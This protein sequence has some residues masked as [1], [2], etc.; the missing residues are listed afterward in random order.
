MN[1]FPPQQ[2]TLAGILAKAMAASRTRSSWNDRLAHWERPASNTEEAQIERAAGMVRRV[3]A[4]NQ[5]LTSEGVAIQAQ[6]SYFNNTNVR[7]EA[8]MDLRA[9]HPLIYTEYGDGVV[10]A[11]AQQASGRS[12]VDRFGDEV[13]REMRR[14]MA[15]EFERAFGRGVVTVGTKAIR[16]DKK[17][18]SRADVDVVPTVG[19]RWVTWCA[20]TG[21]YHEE[22]GIAIFSENGD[23][24]RNYPD[25]HNRNGIDKRSRTRLRF[26]RIVRSLKWLRDELVE[27]GMLKLKQVP[28]FLIECLVYLV[29]DSAFLVEEDDRFDRI[30]RVLDELENMVSDAAMVQNATELNGI[31][32]LFHPSQPWT[33]ADAKA[34]VA[35]AK[36]RLKY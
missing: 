10:P 12:L 29:P 21:S 20:L 32:Y 7:Q 16:I 34:F 19:Y 25:Q 28:S 35:A 27:I 2:N 33:V 30:L 1:A 17:I 14:E 26:K 31:K 24:T 18:G 4:G 36:A 23:I 3:F 5:F 13:C 22:S 15:R 9:T 6:G 11:Y 8:D